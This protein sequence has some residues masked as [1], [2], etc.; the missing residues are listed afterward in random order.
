MNPLQWKNE[1]GYLLKNGYDQP[2]PFEKP[3]ITGIS[4]FTP[5]FALMA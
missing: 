5:L 2:W 4:T 3:V 1:G